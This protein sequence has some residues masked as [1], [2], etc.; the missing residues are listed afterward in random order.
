MTSNTYSAAQLEAKLASFLTALN[1]SA[2]KDQAQPAYAMQPCV[3]G[4]SDEN[5]KPVPRENREA[6]MGAALIN[7]TIPGAVSAGPG[8][9]DGA[10]SVFCRDRSS[11]SGYGVYRPN[12]QKDHYIIAA[13]DGGVTIISGPDIGAKVA[14]SPAPQFSVTVL[15]NDRAIGLM[16]YQSLPSPKQVMESLAK[17]E[18]VWMVSRIAG[19]EKEVQIFTPGK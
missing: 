13:G 14:K 5:A 1:L 6:I 11:Q 7:S 10:R 17:P 8:A 15:T 19:K 3:D 4:L 18:A 16:P 12:G 2:A 9:K